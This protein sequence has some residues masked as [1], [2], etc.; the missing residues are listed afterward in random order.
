MIPYDFDYAGHFSQG[1]A[2]VKPKGKN[3]KYGYID[4]QGNLVIKPVFT[5]AS[6]FKNELAQIIIGNDYESYQY[7]YIDKRGHYVWE[8]SR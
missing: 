6:P 5:S 4:L 7:G 2:V 3:Q 1:L 8:P